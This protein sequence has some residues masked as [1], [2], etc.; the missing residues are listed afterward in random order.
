[1]LF[2][3]LAFCHFV[4]R[5]CRFFA[6]LHD[7]AAPYYFAIFHHQPFYARDVIFSLMLLC[8]LAMRPAPC[9]L[10]KMLCLFAAMRAAVYTL[11][12]AP[13]SIAA[14][15]GYDACVRAYAASCHF[16]FSARHAC[17]HLLR[18]FSFSISLLL[19]RQ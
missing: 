12:N 7:A 11:C 5:H 6:M 4:L 16:L 10:S 1:M 8:F 15:G 18:C 3:I 19:P 13:F 17:R 9:F 14:C 2:M